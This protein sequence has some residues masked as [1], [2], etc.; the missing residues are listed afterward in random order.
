[1]QQGKR[2][3]LTLKNE[4]ADDHPLHLHRHLFELRHIAGTETSGIVKDV[5]LVPAK[6]TVEVEFTADN[7]GAT[8]LHCH[9]QDHM[10]NGFMTLLRYA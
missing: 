6:E 4:S 9:Q 7:P 10:D 5:V 2:Y 3:R 8:L 1:L